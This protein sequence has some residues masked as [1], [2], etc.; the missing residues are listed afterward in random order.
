MPCR[1]RCRRPMPTWADTK[2]IHPPILEKKTMKK[3]L[4][5]ALTAALSPL[6]AQN[7]AG[8][9]VAATWP[10]SQ[11]VGGGLHL[12]DVTKGTFTQLT[13]VSG[14]L[15]RARSITKDPYSVPVYYVG[16]TAEVVTTLGDPNIYRLVMSGGKVA[17]VTK[18]NTNS[19][20]ND[21]AIL[22]LHVV[23]DEI[24]FLSKTRL[25]KMPKAGGKETT[26]STVTAKYPVM[27]TDG[28]WIYTNLDSTG[29]YASATIYK[30][31]PQ[32]LKKWVTIFTAGAPFPTFVTNLTV[33]GDGY[34]N[35]IDR[36]NFSGHTLSVVNP[37]TGTAVSQ[38]PLNIGQFGTSHVLQDP[39]T[40]DYVAL[41]TPPL[42]STLKGIGA[43]VYN[44]GKQTK[45]FF[46]GIT[47]QIGGLT[48]QR[49]PHLHKFGHTCASTFKIEPRMWAN[50]VPEPGNAAYAV[51][52]EAPANTVGILILGA[53]GALPGPI[54]LPNAGTCVLGVSP[55][56][57]I[58]GAVPAAGTLSVGLPL[59][60][61][62]KPGAIDV[63][64]AIL[65][66][67]ANKSGLVTTQ[68]GSII[69]N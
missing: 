61:S 23:G 59:P 12:V 42:G 43:V 48:V 62:L 10:D 56:L 45:T 18:L 31:D 29:A 5:L 49:S 65:D 17:Q 54:A 51:T 4:A 44:G 53:H 16:T 26:I 52:L 6:A 60:S 2:P 34:L 33:D 66:S 67:A 58:S 36:G 25:A 47:G 37:L 15:T 13:G 35:V 30:V 14:D 32:D 22:Q 39:K 9:F 20:K 41:G 1:T 46:G 55:V 50:S 40:K 63:Q 8:D 27:A 68:V 19:L 24:W 3:Y 7:T 38:V 57:L 69:T 28:R 64:W 21:G 11:G